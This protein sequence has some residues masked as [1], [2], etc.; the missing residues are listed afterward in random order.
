MAQIGGFIERATYRDEGRVKE[1]RG[2][3]QWGALTMPRVSGQGEEI[4]FQRPVRTGAVGKGL[5][6]G[7]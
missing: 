6:G 2:Q 7:N 1:S 3:R 5:S 4:G